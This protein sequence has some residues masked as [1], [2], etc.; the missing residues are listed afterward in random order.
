[1]YGGSR[2]RGASV[3]IEFYCGSLRLSTCVAST[4]VANGPGRFGNLGRA[5]ES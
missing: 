5:V 1:M 4:R 3:V 2:D